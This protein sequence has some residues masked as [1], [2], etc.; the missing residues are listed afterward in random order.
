MTK[1][2]NIN[3]FSITSSDAS[4]KLSQTIEDYRLISD[5]SLRWRGEIRL[6]EI[7]PQF[8][9]AGEVVY[10]LGFSK[11]REIGPGKLK[12]DSIIE[13]ISLEKDYS[14]G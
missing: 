14:F 3:L 2:V 9:D 10:F 11:E 12:K 5:L 6:D 4:A 8:N 13:G 7:K 1:Y